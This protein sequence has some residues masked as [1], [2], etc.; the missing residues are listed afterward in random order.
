MVAVSGNGGRRQNVVYSSDSSTKTK[1]ERGETDALLTVLVGEP[2]HELGEA[3]GVSSVS[4][5]EGEPRRCRGRPLDGEVPRGP[6]LASRGRRGRRRSP[7][8]VDE[9]GEGGGQ[10]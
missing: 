9:A 3:G 6:L 10:T 7:W 1:G 4:G 5:K 8:R 2:S